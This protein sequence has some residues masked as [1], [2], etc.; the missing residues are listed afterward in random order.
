MAKYVGR[1]YC[2][3]CG[4]GLPDQI[5]LTDT[6]ARLCRKHFEERTG[7][8]PPRPLTADDL[9]P[10][11]V[12]KAQPV[13]TKVIPGLRAR[14]APGL[15]HG[16]ELQAV[17]NTDDATVVVGSWVIPDVSLIQTFIMASA[18]RDA[19]AADRLMVIQALLRILHGTSR[20]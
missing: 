19:S 15:T 9:T 12:R 13:W 5:W 14:P 6:A 16:I 7:S 2:D 3:D 10:V 8:P 20:P 11:E 17:R 1:E 18:H 4:H